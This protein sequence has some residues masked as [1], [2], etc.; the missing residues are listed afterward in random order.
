MGAQVD[1]HDPHIAEIHTQREHARLDGRRRV[2]F[3]QAIVS[4]YDAALIATDHS[5]IDY[6]DLVEWSQVV[7]DTR[8]ATR[9]VAAR[10]KIV[11]A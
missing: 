6:G 9:G 2:G 10:E 1:F 11:R 3:D 8:N 7:V 5:A 4:A